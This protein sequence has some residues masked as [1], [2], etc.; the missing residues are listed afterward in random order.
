MDEI[1]KQERSCEIDPTR[2]EK[3]EEVDAN[4]VVLLAYVDW[5][6]SRIFG[7]GPRRLLF[8]VLFLV[9]TPPSNPV[10]TFSHCPPP[11]RLIFAHLSDEVA[12]KYPDNENLRYTAVSGYLFLRFFAAAILGPKLFGLTAEHPSQK[13]SRALTLIS[14]TVQQLANL[15]VFEEKEPYMGVVL[16][17]F[18]LKNRENMKAFLKKLATP[19][20]P[21]DIKKKDSIIEKVW[22]GS[23]LSCFGGKLKIFRSCM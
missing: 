4:K 3:G 15:L 12:K 17:E 6:I 22:F 14:K 1:I 21:K 20:D 19:P 8:L 7:T 13:N 11:L 18:M 10:E 9:L 16:N 2:L 23:P 5:T